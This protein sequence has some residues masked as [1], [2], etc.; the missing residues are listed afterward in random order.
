M[1][2]KVDVLFTHDTSP[3]LC[4]VSSVLLWNAILNTRSTSRA[5]A[6]K[7]NEVLACLNADSAV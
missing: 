6:I 5:W 7:L 4:Y 3:Q 1:K 2:K